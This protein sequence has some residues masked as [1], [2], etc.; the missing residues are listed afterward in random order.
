MGIRIRRTARWLLIL[1]SLLVGCEGK[2]PAQ[3]TP[4]LAIVISVDQMRHDYLARF[5]PYFGRG[6]STG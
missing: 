5:S 4:R 6:D 2:P 1:F 3:N